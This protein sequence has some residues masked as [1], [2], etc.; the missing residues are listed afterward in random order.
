MTQSA[1]SHQ[2]RSLEDYLGQPLFKRVKRRVIVTDAGHDLL[3]TVEDMLA[4]LEDGI[5]RLDQ[6]KKPHQFIVHT[7]SAFASNFLVPRLDAFKTAQPELDVWLYTTDG[8][9][10]IELTE[11]H[12]A[13]LFGRGS[14]PE[15]YSRKLIPEVY[16]PFCSPEFAEHYRMTEPES[17]LDSPLLHAE[18]RESWTS[19][20]LA[21]GLR[22]VNPVL[23]ANFTNPAILLQAARRGQ[24]VA[25]GSEV[26]A[27]DLVRGGDLICPIDRP[28]TSSYGYYFVAR[29]EE[30]ERPMVMEFLTWIEGV[31]ATFAD[32]R[33]QI[34]WNSGGVHGND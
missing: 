20:F 6:Y 26:L 17:V 5:R 22:D 3:K 16:R 9:P 8:E 12:A 13:I 29:H 25:L 10:D 23:G 24:G 21:Q 30:M 18:L 19:W 11:V 15:F 1:I 32:A 2:V 28:Y 34:D 14:W 31:S 7:S 4:H 27:Y 33:Q